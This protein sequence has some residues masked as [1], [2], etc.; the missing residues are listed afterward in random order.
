MRARFFWC[1]TLSLLCHPQAW[2]QTLTKQFPPP[3]TWQMPALQSQDDGGGASETNP[4]GTVPIAQV[5]PPPPS[6]VPVHITAREQGKRGDLWTL[7]EDV[8]ILYRGYTLHADK[9]TYNE[10][11]SEVNALGHL[12]VEGGPDDES[13]YAT[14]GTMNLDA[15]T[16]HFYDVNGTIGNGAPPA[17]LRVSRKTFEPT[18][19]FAFEGREVIKLGPGQYRVI[20]GTMTSCSLPKPDWQIISSRIDVNDQKASSRYAHFNLIGV[21]VLFLPYVTH[22]VTTENRQTG[23]L[24]PVLGTSTT[25]GLVTGDEIYWAINRS[26]DLTVG[27]EYYSKRGFAPNAQ[28]RYRGQGLDYANARFHALL[29]R[30]LEPGNINQGGVDVLVDARRDLSPDTRAVSDVEYLSSYVYRQAF[31]ENVS[32]ATSSEVKSQVFLQQEHRGIAEDAYFGRYQVFESDTTGDEI[33]ILHLPSVHADAVDHPIAGTRLMWGYSSALDLLTRSEPGFHARNVFRL[34]LHPHLVMPV[35]LGGWTITPEAGVRETFYSKS[36]NLNPGADTTSATPNPA[37]LNRADFE[38]GL[39]IRPAVVQR[40][41]SGGWLSRWLGA[42]LRHTIQPAISYRYV[43]GVNN[44]NSVLRIDDRDVV[45]NT[46]QVEY[47]LTQRLYLRHVHGHRCRDD[48]AQTPDGICG[49][50]TVDWLSWKVAQIY[51][52]DPS[53]GGAVISDAPNVF[54]ATLNFTGVAFVYRPRSYSPVISRLRMRT[55]STTDLEWDMDYD[56]KA[57]RFNSNN[58]YATYK[59][60]NYNFSLGSFQLSALESPASSPRNIAGSITKF[61]QLRVLLAYGNSS[62][63]GLGVGGNAGYDFE[64]HTLQFGG[65]QA[66][67]NWNCCGF[68]MEYRRYS[69]GPVR[70]ETQYLWSISLAGVATAGNLRQALRIF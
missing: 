39:D 21:P 61:Q 69:L 27:S 19:P 41:F 1:I 13:I 55:S 12:H 58:L 9:I 30:G 8:V 32:I 23:F 35:Y 26:S 3:E 7:T 17:R 11:T 34:D 15:E 18:N 40:D 52:F 62:K 44:F 2:P 48:E 56:T 36:E 59:H 67:Y 6:G 4:G 66:S 37:S 47:S 20:H 29:D 53:F 42:D 43:T 31:E 65:V 33:R 38:A 49:S 68:S 64:N 5:V 60:D 50:G 45:S 14:H 25:K 54:A 24:L 46:N 57:G 63:R 10:A 16:G 22:P 28:F 70:D 51:F